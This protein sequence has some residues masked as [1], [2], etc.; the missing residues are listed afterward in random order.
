MGKRLVL[1]ALTCIFLINMHITVKA[2]NLQYIRC[3][4]YTAKAD[5]ITASGKVVKE[6]Y[7]A[8]KRE[9]IGK[10]CKLYDKDKNVIGTFEFAD[11]GAG[12]DT[13]GDGK[14][15]S[16]KCGKSIDVYRS[17]LKRCYDWIGQ[18]GDYVYMEVIDDD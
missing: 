13:D 8:G 5:A 11:T 1:I 17:S 10:T 6:S 4:C 12:I 7:I 18:Y 16:I 14:G 3:T 9:W 2:N 15:D